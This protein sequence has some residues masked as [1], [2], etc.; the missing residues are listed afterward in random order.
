MRD[1]NNKEWVIGFMCGNKH[2][3]TMEELL[4][5]PTVLMDEVV[6]SCYPLIDCRNSN[7]KKFSNIDKIS[8]VLK[9]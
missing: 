5:D 9:G 8:D 4:A 3:N 7:G 6:Y 1:A 2:Y